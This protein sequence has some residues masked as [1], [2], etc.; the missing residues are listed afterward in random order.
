MVYDI[1]TIEFR[2]KYTHT[3]F[4]V[5]LTKYKIGPEINNSR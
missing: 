5:L 3:Q 1:G 4:K 2:N